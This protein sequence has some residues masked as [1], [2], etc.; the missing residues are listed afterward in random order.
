MR[1]PLA[2]LDWPVSTDRLL[3]RRAA[4]DDLDA[5]WTY[6]Q[7][8]E[9]YEWIGS[10]ATTYD[11]YRER[12]LRQERLADVL[13]V[14]L[15]GRVIGDLTLWIQDAYAQEEVADQAKDV[16]AEIGWTLDPA[17]GGKG[18]ATEA[19]RALIDV[20]FRGLG[21]RRLYA[22][23]FS[24]NEPSW[25]LMERVGMRREQHTVK[26]S[27]HRTKGWLDGFAYALLAEEWLSPE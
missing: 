12:F 11:G 20:A 15:D 18:Y 19:V 2:T 5:T 8:P 26:E 13:V 27:L 16:Q 3:L 17:F 7:L 9:V 10:A 24:D 4:P 23:C 1:H 21:L 14:E 6:R 22:G 25:R